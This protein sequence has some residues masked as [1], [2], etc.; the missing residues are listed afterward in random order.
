MARPIDFY[1][2]F[3]SP[4]SYLGAQLIEPLAARHGRSVTWRPVLLGA[5]FKV[6]G[7]APLTE[8]PL[9]GDYSRVDF[10]RS[11]RFHGLPY[12]HPEPFP[13]STVN[14]ARAML[15]WLAEAPA[16]A[17]DFARGALQAFFVENRPIND[18]AEIGRLTAELG[19]DAPALLAALQAPALKER[20]RA[21]V[22]EAVAR[23]V[24]GAPFFFV[25]D[26]PFWGQDRLP[27][28]ARWLAEGPY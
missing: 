25:D 3:S 6:S 16:R 15:W 8:I 28:I 5:I 13:I 24:F 2:D 12:R 22:D 10:A 17:P 7:M 1:F 4:Y 11:A 20:L 18:P 21:A 27:Q 19:G 23:G 14:T 9:K 26:E